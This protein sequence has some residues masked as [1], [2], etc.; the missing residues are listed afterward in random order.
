MTLSLGDTQY[1]NTAIML[2][3]IML[4]VSMLSVVVLMKHFHVRGFKLPTAKLHNYIL[5][6]RNKKARL[7][8]LNFSLS[9]I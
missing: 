6:T 8:D 3:V 4:S 7:F 9:L 1:N 2:I 5:V